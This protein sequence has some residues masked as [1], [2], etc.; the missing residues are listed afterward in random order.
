[1][2]ARITKHNG[3]AHQIS[4]RSPPRTA[5]NGD[6]SSAARTQTTPVAQMRFPPSSPGATTCE[7]T[8]FVQF[9]NS[10]HHHLDAAVPLRSALTALQ[11]TLRL[12][13]PPLY[14]PPFCC[15]HIW[16]TS[17]HHYSVT[18]TLSVTPYPF[19]AN[20]YT[21]SQ[22]PNLSLLIFPHPSSLHL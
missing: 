4:Q 13:R 19:S 5:D 7:K 16:T 3:T 8:Q 21:L 2:Q 12:C 22:I 9:L 1:M 17:R 10:K 18:Y 15:L 11:S 6:H 20:P 14:S